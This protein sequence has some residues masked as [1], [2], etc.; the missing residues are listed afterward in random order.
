MSLFV[1]RAFIHLRNLLSTH[2][3]LAFKLAELEKKIE[4]HDSEIS[5]LFDAIHELM[6]PPEKSRRHIGFHAEP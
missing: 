1:V 3:E 4:T 2:K 5:S 6:A